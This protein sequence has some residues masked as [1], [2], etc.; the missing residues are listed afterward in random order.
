MKTRARRMP[1]CALDVRERLRAGID[2]G[3]PQRDVRLDRRR[4]VGRALEPDRPGAVVAAAARAARSRASGRS[5]GSRRPS[6]WS[7]KRCSAIIVAFDSS[8]PTHQPPG[9]WSSSRRLV[10]GVDGPVEAGE[11]AASQRSYRSPRRGATPR[12]DRAPPS[13]PASPWRSTRRRGRRLAGGLHRPRSYASRAE[14]RTS[15][16][17]RG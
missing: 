2:A 6:T 9:C 4:E 5:R 16:A 8:S 15:R 10:A 11:L 14:R 1:P 17:A 13:S 7:Q 12:A 3:H